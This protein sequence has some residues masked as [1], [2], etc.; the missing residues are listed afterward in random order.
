MFSDQMHRDVAGP[1]HHLRP[2]AKR[3]RQFARVRSSAI[4]LRGVGVGDRPGRK[5]LIES[6]S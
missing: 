5:R 1:V 3:A 6:S 2:R 4:A